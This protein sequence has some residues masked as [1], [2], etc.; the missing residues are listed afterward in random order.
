MVGRPSFTSPPL[1]FPLPR[2][3]PIK[4]GQDLLSTPHPSPSLLPHHSAAAAEAVRRRPALVADLLLRLSFRVSELWVRFLVLLAFF[5]FLSHR[6][7]CSGT[8]I[9]VAPASS[10]AARRRR[11]PSPHWP[12]SW[13]AGAIRLARTVQIKR[14][15]YPLDRSAVD[16]W[17]RS[18]APV[19]GCT[20]CLR[21]RQPITVRHMALPK[22]FRRLPLQ[23]CKIKPQFPEF[24]TMPFHLERPLRIS[25]DFHV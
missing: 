5:L 7:W 22:P 16:R 6:V 4:D 11:Q 1:A 13:T 18:T 12:R 24:T 3:R 15:S 19:H 10:A 20:S 17:T 8:R 23:F 25:P 21:Q 14:A 2:L 9:R